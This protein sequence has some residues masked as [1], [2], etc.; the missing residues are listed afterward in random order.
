MFY[1]A[2][3]VECD[4]G[5]G[6]CGA[7]VERIGRGATIAQVTTQARSE[8]WSISSAGHFCPEHRQRTNIHR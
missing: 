6:N 8:G 3:G 1:K 7:Q 5:P 4:H 2:M